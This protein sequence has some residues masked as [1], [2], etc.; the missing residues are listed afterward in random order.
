MA[1]KR[2]RQIDKAM[3][4]QLKHDIISRHGKKAYSKSVADYQLML[5]KRTKKYDGWW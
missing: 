4:E 3:F 2:Q 1:N 5:W